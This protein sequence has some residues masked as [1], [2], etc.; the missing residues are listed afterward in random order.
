M[1][2]IATRGAA[3]GFE[4]TSASAP[5]MQQDRAQP[6]SCKTSRWGDL[7]TPRARAAGMSV[8]KAEGLDCGRLMLSCEQMLTH[9]ASHLGKREETNTERQIST[10]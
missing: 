4:L 6:L 7:E 3:A 8:L 9:H 1:E 2:T 10:S 5:A